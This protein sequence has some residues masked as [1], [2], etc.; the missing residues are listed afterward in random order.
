MSRRPFGLPIT[1][2]I[3]ALAGWGLALVGWGIAVA[4]WLAPDPEPP[5]P[6]IVRVPAD[7]LPDPPPYPPDPPPP[8]PPP[9]PAFEA[10]LAASPAY[11]SASIGACVLDVDG[12]VLYAPPG[13]R[14][15]LTPA[16]SLKT[17]TTATALEVLGP[18]YVFRTTIVAAAGPDEEGALA[19]DLF[20]VGGGDPTLSPADI[21]ALASRLH[22][23][24]LRHVVGAIIADAGVFPE[25]AAND[26]W[27]W[28][29][30]G[31]AYGAG[32]FGLNLGHNR[33]LA[34]FDP[35][36]AV[37][38][39]AAFCGSTPE[40]PGIA[41]TNLVNTGAAGSGDGVVIHGGPYSREL[42]LRGTVPLGEPGFAVGG[43]IP[44]PPHL[45]AILLAEALRDC[46]ITIG[47]E[48]SV[49]RG[50]APAD[51][52]PLAD[53]ASPPISAILPHLHQTSD[54][55]EAQCLYLAV[56]NKK[57][58]DPGT[59]V[60]AHWRLR[61]VGLHGHR[62]L[63]GSGLARAN[64]IRPLDLAR[65]NYAA[66]HGTQGD[67]FYESLV[68]NGHL[69]TKGGAMSGVRAQVGFATLPDGR[70]LTFALIANALPPGTGIWELRDALL[71]SVI[72]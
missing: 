26:H 66:R 56:G 20:L 47:G 34:H 9:T 70:E 46:G 32:A 4:L 40:L 27:N 22:Q 6:T 31:N 24:G 1:T 42:T 55:L 48:A 63:D 3:L 60:A 19:G 36:E 59:V 72:E 51:A 50:S 58:A 33:F 5:P 23:S 49:E 44:D 45:A 43:A 54:N 38:D 53:H 62:L 17:V 65:I 39:P 57:A 21:S 18:D 69:R 68:G 52:V 25:A 67:T 2:A 61:G 12:A 35:G 29:D 11:A 16:S 30:V 37:G 8:L 41:W 71:E 13:A 64:K 15:A 28:G 7:P 14:T 10:L